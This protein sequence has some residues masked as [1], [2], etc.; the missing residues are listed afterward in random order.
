M[1]ET[2]LATELP[3]GSNVKGDV[4]GASWMF[5][6]LDLQP[7]RTVCLG[8]PPPATLA[9]VTRLSREVLLVGRLN[10]HGGA[11]IVA[12]DG[13][14]QGARRHGSDRAIPLPDRS[15]DLVLAADPSWTARLEQDP[16]LQAEVDRLLRPGGCLYLPMREPPASDGEG[17]DLL[18]QQL[19]NGE[20]RAIAPL[21]DSQAAAFLSAA[22]GVQRSRRGILGRARHARRLPLRAQTAGT[23][24]AAALRGGHGDLRWPPRYLVEAAT[25]AG[26]PIED[27]RWALLSAGQ[28]RTKKVLIYL[29]PPGGAAPDYIVKLTRHPDFN[30]RVENEHRA[31]SE[32][33]R[34]GLAAGSVPRAVFYG[35][36]AGVAFIGETALR[37]TPLRERATARPDCPHALAALDW[38]VELGAASADR[39][40]RAAEVAAALGTLLDRF[41][42]I[43]RPGARY[44]A[45]LAEQIAEL[46]RHR[47]PFPVVFAHGDAGMWNVLLDEAG[48]P[49]FLDWE[50]ADPQGPPLWDVLY[51]FRS[52]AVA[53]ARRAGIRD[54]LRAFTHAFLEASALNQ[55]LCAVV[56]RYCA[57][58]GLA[59]SLVKPLLYTCWMHRSLKEAKTLS[60]R[61]LW[62][63]HYAGA[64]I[65]CIDHHDA[66]GLVNLFRGAS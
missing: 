24:A 62:R 34:R 38:L 59:R 18:W 3:P 49:L 1:L 45:F 21:N 31:L 65:Q 47:E 15:V 40:A 14:G 30:G 35:V 58:V 26:I 39:T 13:K 7:Q 16:G 23:T 20:P 66:P 11:W 36:Q 41:A 50:A 6:L 37:G 10:R 53:V 22:A 32:L 63:G 57:E 4:A 19:V 2:T 42:S 12:P 52:H 33:E 56:E 5:L 51:F 27:H 28:Y 29:F 9:T 54:R 17:N 43:Y 44:Q 46:G 60:E 64:L 25:A 48:R 55:R 61:T 8:H